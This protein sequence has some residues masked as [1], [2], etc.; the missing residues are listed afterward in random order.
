M[1]RFAAT[2]LGMFILAVV[3]S[4]FVPRQAAQTK[5]LRVALTFDDLPD[6]GPLPPGMTRVDV[7]RQIIAALKA[8]SAP[9]VYGF[10][11]AK[12]LET[13]PAD[14]EVLKLWGEAGFPPGNHTY[15]HMNLHTNSPDDFERDV[16]ANEA[17]LRSYM[18]NGD[19]H[20]FRYPYLR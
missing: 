16:E 4:A 12:Q 6:H 7:A 8:R 14:A 10:I 17:T 19:W 3:V 11:N 5:Q 9:A 18:A 2:V 13:R 15:S 20:W 1:K